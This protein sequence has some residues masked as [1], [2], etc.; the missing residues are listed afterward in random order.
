M[1]VRVRTF[2]KPSLSPRQTPVGTTCPNQ[3][4]PLSSIIVRPHSHFPRLSAS[5]NTLHRR[6]FGIVLRWPDLVAVGGQGRT[7]RCG[8]FGCSR[9][10]IRANHGSRT[11]CPRP[12]TRT[13]SS[14]TTYPLLLSLYTLF[15][16]RRRRQRIG[17]V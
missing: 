11:S 15:S 7:P 2:A 12:A 8:E 3:L 16:C 6:P 13:L 4:N 14:P 1:R 5:R 9:H 17:S 10:A